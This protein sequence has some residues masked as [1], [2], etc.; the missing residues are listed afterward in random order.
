MTAQQGS[1]CEA[2]GM[3]MLS[4]EDHGA[5]DVNNP[6]CK[7]CTNPDGSN[8]PYEEVYEGVVQAYMVGTIPGSGRLS[9]GQAEKQAHYIDS[10]PAWAGRRP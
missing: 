10:L 7:Y 6:R 8:K 9:R 3:P 1:M 5:G 4:P 2:C